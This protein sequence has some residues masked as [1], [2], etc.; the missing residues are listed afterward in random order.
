MIKFGNSVE[1]CGGTHVSST[2]KIGLFKII[3]EGAVAAGVRRIEAITN[4]AAEDFYKDKASKVET[5]NEI[6]KNPKDL[7]KAV[8]DLVVKNKQLQ[9]QIEQ[10]QKEKAMLLKSEIKNAIENINGINFIGTEVE[11]DGGS[12]KDILFQLKAET[13][14]LF[15]VIGG[16]NDG[17][18]T[19]SIIVS[20]NLIAEKELNAGNIIREASKFI[21]G[22]GG[23][24]PAF[25]TA[26]GK[27]PDGLKQA[28]N[29]VKE[30][31]K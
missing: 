13:E 18:C 11:L 1:L 4:I 28:I 9:K 14:N 8:G 20:D 5:L 24:Q 10:F 3:S 17:I 31:I 12:I 22:G 16:K 27:N 6:L 29:L 23:G 15:A 26:G 19:L 2:G 21:Q 25:A 30:K 7:T